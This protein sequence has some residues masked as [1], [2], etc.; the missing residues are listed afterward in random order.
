M[1]VG[2]LCR[3]MTNT[4]VADLERL[5]DRTVKALDTLYMQQQVEQAGLPTPRA[6]GRG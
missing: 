1:H 2:A 5:H 4:A 3:E 6:I